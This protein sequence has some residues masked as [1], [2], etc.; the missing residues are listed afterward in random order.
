MITLIA[1]LG[2]FLGLP[3]LLLFVFKSNAGIMFLASCSG[4][5][6]L[7]SLDP[8]VVS[9]AGAIIPS[10]GEAYIR[11]A[12]VI[13][14]MVFASMLFKNS[15]KTSL[16]PL[17]ILVIIL[18]ASTLWLILPYTTGVSW[19]MENTR[20]STWQDLKEFKT[21]FVAGGISMSL[22]VVMLQQ[23]KHSKHSKH[24]KR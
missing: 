16:L 8:A 19:L 20:N 1:S 23:S 24:S 7:D 13:L 18:L 12:V 22:L 14:T 2:L 3:L 6:L 10:E 17:H 4:L 9:T 5:V 11:L 21:L 15:L